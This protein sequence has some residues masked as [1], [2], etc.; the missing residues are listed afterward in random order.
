MGWNI[1]KWPFQRGVL[2]K[3][4]FLFPELSF[5]FP[6]LLFYF[7]EVLFCFT[8]VP[9]YFSK[10]PSFPG[11]PFSFPEVPLF[12]Y[13]ACL[14]PR[15]PFFPADC[16]FSLSCSELL[17]EIIFA[18]LLFFF[19]WKSLWTN[20]WCLLDNFGTSSWNVI[21]YAFYSNFSFHD[22]LE[23]AVSEQLEWLKCQKFSG[24]SAPKFPR[25]GVGLTANP[26]PPDVLR[27]AC[28]IA[29]IRCP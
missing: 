29:K 20:F 12:M 15:M 19:S 4:A 13:C 18:L 23:N 11:F 6:E 7:P 10:I 14:F 17:R 28:G 2:L 27:T 22:S 21:C 26:K 24:S 25:R 8:E 5:Y 16:T 9:F 3:N 1:Q